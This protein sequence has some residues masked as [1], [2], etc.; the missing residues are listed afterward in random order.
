MGRS[1]E[2]HKAY[3]Q[4]NKDQYRRNLTRR[5]AERRL[6]FRKLKAGLVC[7]CGED[8]PGCI[9][10]HHNDPTDKRNDVSR[11]VRQALAEEVILAEIAKCRVV[12]SNC[13]RKLH[14]EDADQI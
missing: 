7:E 12:C 6:W 9:D 10:F 14:W 1:A 11:M 13:H 8:H 2:E 3:Y 5:R 4:E